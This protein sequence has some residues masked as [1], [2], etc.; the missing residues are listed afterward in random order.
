MFAR[1]Q[2][3]QKTADTGAGSL[4]QP[5]TQLEQRSTEV[6]AADTLYSNIAPRS[7]SGHKQ[8]NASFK[9][10]SSAPKSKQI[11]PKRKQSVPKG[12][13]KD[14]ARQQPKPRNT[15]KVGAKGGTS[16]VK[17]L[18]KQAISN[19]IESRAQPQLPL[20]EAEDLLIQELLAGIPSTAWLP[21]DPLTSEGWFTDPI[22]S[23]ITQ[24]TTTHPQKELPATNASSSLI[25]FSTASSH[26]TLASLQPGLVSDAQS[27]Q[28]TLNSPL[29]GTSL[30][31]AVGQQAQTT[32]D[33]RLMASLRTKKDTPLMS[34]HNAKK[35]NPLSGFAKKHGIGF[36]VGNQ[37]AIL[38]PALLSSSPPN[39]KQLRTHPYKYYSPPKPTQRPPHNQTKGRN[40]LLGRSSPL[41]IQAGTPYASNEGRPVERTSM[42]QKGVS[43]VDAH[44]SFRTSQAGSVA[45]TSA[46]GHIST[47]PGAKIGIKWEIAQDKLLLHG[48]RQ[49]RWMDIAKPRDPA[50]FL[51]N[52]WEVISH[53][54]TLGSG[55]ARSARQ[56]R[57]RWAVMHS[58]LGTAIMDFVDSA[59]TPQS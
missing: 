36:P 24:D 27:L 56:C 2:D 41:R 10:P 48:V 35:G 4:Q 45:S 38:S 37:M 22:S 21:T 59:P 20:L 54:V 1:S 40:L 55:V 16:K 32:P 57:R 30:A 39:A 3:S 58:H 25:S 28:E 34:R 9:Q 43:H 47:N 53:G 52:D 5:A 14:V 23:F 11:V 7:V 17:E 6:S 8:Q 33:A 51:G 50:R 26:S 49:Q 19:S 15:G 46:H 29:Q 44:S 42:S 18:P 31:D 13:Q 12:K